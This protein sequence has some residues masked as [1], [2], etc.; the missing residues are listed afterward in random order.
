MIE[1]VDTPEINPEILDKAREADQPQAPKRGRGRPKKDEQN[2]K[3]SSAKAES[4]NDKTHNIPT[5]II[6]YPIVKGISMTAAIALKDK[7]AE[8]NMTEAEFMAEGMAQVFDKHLP[9]I[10]GQYG[11][12]IVLLT[13]FAQYG[14]RL[15][16]LSQQIKA[17]K[18]A[19]QGSQ[20]PPPE[21]ETP[22]DFK[23]YDP[24][25]AVN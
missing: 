23:K 21:N 4:K 16:I 10:L 13:A 19:Q 2:Q 8:M 20:P 22:R 18:R 11:A 1:L 5:K 24:F 7:R 3:T 6:C 12:E 25:E 14:A 15:T 9:A 17:E